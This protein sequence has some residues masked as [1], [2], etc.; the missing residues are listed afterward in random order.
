[1]I[2]VGKNR[3]KLVGFVSM[4]LAEERDRLEL[5]VGNRLRWKERMAELTSSISSHFPH[6]IYRQNSTSNKSLKL[7]NFTNFQQF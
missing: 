5:D 6:N 4:K 2:D 7:Q 3:L 1:M